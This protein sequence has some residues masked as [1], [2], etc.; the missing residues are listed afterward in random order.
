MG[1]WL[2]WGLGSGMLFPP[3]RAVV[4]GRQ[5]TPPKNP[6]A[7]RKADGSVPAMTTRFLGILAGASLFLTGM[8]PLLVKAE[9]ASQQ[10][11]GTGAAGQLQDGAMQPPTEPRT[12][13]STG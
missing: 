4:T 8:A 12:R 13:G 10:D 2:S 9:N 6:N 7:N 11:D 1:C 5:G 3:A